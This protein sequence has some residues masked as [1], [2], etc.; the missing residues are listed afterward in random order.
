MADPNTD[1]NTLR[2]IIVRLAQQGTSAEDLEKVANYYG[3]SISN[4]NKALG[5]QSN[6][7]AIA[8][9][10]ALKG[11]SNVAGIGGDIYNLTGHAANWINN[12]IY[13]TMGLEEPE[14]FK[15]IYGGT[16][17]QV[18]DAMTNAGWI[19]APEAVP[20]EFSGRFLSNVVEGGTAGA[21]LSPVLPAAGSLA[22]AGSNM[23][24]RTAGKM[25]EGTISGGAAGGAG[26][27]AQNLF[28]DDQITQILSSIVAGRAAEGV[29]GLPGR[30]ANTASFNPRFGIAGDYTATEVPL[31]IGGVNQS[32][33]RTQDAL[34]AIPGGG[35]MVTSRDAALHGLDESVGRF[36]NKVS[37]TG[38][39]GDKFEGGM[40]IQQGAKE[41]RQNFKNEQ[42]RL[43]GNEFRGRLPN[44]AT[45][46]INNVLRTLVDMRN[47]T[48]GLNNL[49][50]V[51]RNN[52]ID[53]ATRA[54][55]DD[56]MGS[57]QAGRGGEIPLRSLLSF[58][59][60]I[61]E[62]MDDAFMSGK[63][64]GQLDRL[65]KETTQ[66]IKRGASKYGVLKEFNEANAYTKSGHDFIRRNIKNM[67]S[68]GTT[69]EQAFRFSTSD[70]WSGGRLSEMGANL[71]Q[72]PAAKV[73]MQ[74]FSSSVIKN[75]GLD[76]S[77]D[78]SAIAFYKN[79]NKM[80]PRAKKALL[81]DPALVENMDRLGR[82]AGSLKQLESFSKNSKTAGMAH[83]LRLITSGGGTAGA[84][85]GYLV[86]KTP[87][88]A[89]TGAVVGGASSALGSVLSAKAA[90]T[91][92]SWGPFVRFMAEPFSMRDMPNRLQKL[93]RLSRVS[94]ISP[95]V[96][97]AVRELMVKAQK[98]LF[99]KEVYG[100][101]SEEEGQ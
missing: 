7:G 80:T 63:S 40:A 78:F 17:Q 65:Y 47:D 93:Y 97:E 21:V 69:P 13:N 8:K 101:G 66:A 18:R 10:A 28:P 59:Q 33:A 62:A 22:R 35:K 73:H 83:I 49:A 75:M 57:L 24:M 96:R 25:T 72:S 92:L 68:E 11:L 31:T 55:F 1:P 90:S 77:G 81:D 45:I 19:G 36:A 53:D 89:A 44:N 100:A 46:D 23:A 29:F 82:V 43:W 52:V 74:Q 5:P 54:A 94:A 51:F 15:P 98:P 67:A 91:L 2:D 41:W 48:P 34:S 76:S 95:D 88:A 12:Q 30:I 20:Q 79:W 6:T 60:I 71:G 39:A 56:V 64:S 4:L 85:L 9:E 58:R 37:P 26:A 86:G 16:S 99:E 70:M 27:V 32:F 3:T 87:E 61:G 42:N 50:G 14:Q 38:A 84:G